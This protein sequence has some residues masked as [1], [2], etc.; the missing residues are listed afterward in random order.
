LGLIPKDFLENKKMKLSKETLDFLSDELEEMLC[1]CDLTE[2]Q[3]DELGQ[4]LDFLD[5][6][7]ES[8]LT[9]TK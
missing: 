8:E 4:L 5:C 2:T 1:H 9:L 6:P 3:T 7:K